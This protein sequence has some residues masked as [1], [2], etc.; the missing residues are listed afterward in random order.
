MR[1]LRWKMAPV[2][3]DSEGR[4]VAEREK[5]KAQGLRNGEEHDDVTCSGGAA[6][7]A[8]GN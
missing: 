3:P 7:N 6:Q 2:S 1:L 8:K 5:A 4:N